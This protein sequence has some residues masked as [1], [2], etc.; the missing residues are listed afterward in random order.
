MALVPATAVIPTR[1]RPEPLRRALL[2]LASQTRMPAEVVVVDSSSGRES[3]DVVNA[4]APSLPGVSLRWL[5]AEQAGAAVQR[6]QGIE[7]ATQDAILFIDDDVVLEPRCLELLWAALDSD[8]ALGG[9]NAMITNQRYLPPG[10]FSR[11]VFSILNGRSERSFAGRVLG[12]AVNLL[13]EDDD[14]APE[15][16]AVEWL[17]STC[18][19]Y[20]RAAL[21]SPPFDGHFTGYSLME[22]LTLS[23]RV[24]KSWR[25]ANART[26]RLF[27]DS[28]PG[29]HKSDVGEVSRM[30]LVNRHYVMTRILERRTVSD[31]ARF[32]FW[33]SLQVAYALRQHGPGRDFG[34]FLLGKW[35]GLRQLGS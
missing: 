1:N 16:V 19:L 11:T 33:E 20:K 27:H 17:N 32:A 30:E 35:R 28:Q 22:D 31:Y 18:A 29:T 26:A 5:A 21:P 2:S 13:P 25:L 7:A 14:S 4:A 9:V 6:N 3:R 10:R 15:V 24:G 12:P 34:R 23:L 8:A